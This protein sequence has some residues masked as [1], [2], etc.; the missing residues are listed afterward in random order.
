MRSQSD[1]NGP[2]P[3]VSLHCI[4][5]HG[6]LSQVELTVLLFSALLLLLQLR[7]KLPNDFPQYP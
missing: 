2:S 3:P 6:A 4:V 5:M 7:E 1:N